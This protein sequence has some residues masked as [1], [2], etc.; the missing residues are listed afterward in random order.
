MKSSLTA[1]SVGGWVC[2]TFPTP[3]QSWNGCCSVQF[4]VSC[5]WLQAYK[6]NLPEVFMINPSEVLNYSQVSRTYWQSMFKA[7]TKCCYETL[8]EILNKMAFPNLGLCNGRLALSLHGCSADS[9]RMLPLS[10]SG[11]QQQQAS[12]LPASQ[13]LQLPAWHGWWQLVLERSALN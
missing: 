4:I 3:K 11:S 1:Y 7:C 6:K 2:I 13:H 12:L 8:A 10:T 5:P 9:H